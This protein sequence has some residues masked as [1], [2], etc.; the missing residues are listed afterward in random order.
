MG[1]NVD[2]NASVVQSPTEVPVFTPS[3]TVRGIEATN[4]IPSI[5]MDQAV[6]GNDMPH[7]ILHLGIKNK[8]LHRLGPP[9]VGPV[10]S[11]PTANEP[12]LPDFH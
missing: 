11:H 12:G 10:G 6:C 5:P 2:W 8:V 3:S 7:A 4:C 9:V 1:I